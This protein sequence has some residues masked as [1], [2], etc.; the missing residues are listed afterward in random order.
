MN[1]VPAKARS[2]RRADAARLTPVDA[3]LLAGRLAD[4]MLRKHFPDSKGMSIWAVRV[5]KDEVVSSLAAIFQKTGSK[6]TVKKV[7][8]S[9]DRI[10]KIVGPG[11]MKHFLADLAKL[12][13]YADMGDT[14]EITAQGAEG[15]ATLGSRELRNYTKNLLKEMEKE[16]WRE[17]EPLFE[18]ARSHLAA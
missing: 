3:Q 4:R 16:E 6:A 8:S 2:V 10:A 13:E 5:E 17:V 15:I 9:A 7:V 14:I 18:K 12:T 1:T 11:A